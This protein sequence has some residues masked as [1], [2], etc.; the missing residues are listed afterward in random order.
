[1]HCKMYPSGLNS[2][3]A[4]S[5]PAA[6]QVLRAIG[7][8]DFH[9]LKQAIRAVRIQAIGFVCVRWV[10]GRVA[11]MYNDYCAPSGFNP[12]SIL[13]RALILAKEEA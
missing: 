12:V 3:I 6:R 13:D 1:M 4:L 5:D 10:P 11:G 8:M 9:N 2:F 7:E